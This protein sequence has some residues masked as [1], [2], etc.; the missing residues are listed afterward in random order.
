ME[1]GKTAAGGGAPGGGAPGGGVGEHHLTRVLQVFNFSGM[2]PHLVV[3]T[4][5]PESIHSASLFP[6]FHTDTHTETHTHTQTHTHT[7][8]H[9][10]TR[11]HTH[12]DTHRHTHTARQL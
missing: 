1:A 4:V 6:H 11:T 12:T 5:H 8:T 10:Q 3:Y 2:D 7:H 9:T